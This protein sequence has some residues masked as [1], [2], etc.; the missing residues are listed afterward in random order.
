MDHAGRW[1]YRPKVRFAPYSGRTADVLPTTGFVAGGIRRTRVPER[2]VGFSGLLRP[3][4]GG[5]DHLAPLLGFAGDK[6][7]KVGGRPCENQAAQVGEALL[8]PGIGQAGC[9]ARPYEPGHPLGFA[10]PSPTYEQRTNIV[11]RIILL[12]PQKPCTDGMPCSIE[13]VVDRDVG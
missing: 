1:T 11:I 10:T 9:F 4:A 3:D 5:M 6:L 13:G 2:W 7:G 8:G 12:K